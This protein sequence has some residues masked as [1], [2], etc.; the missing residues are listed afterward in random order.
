MGIELYWDD[1][2]LSTLLCVFDGRW[3]WRELTAT[4]K[5]IK[6]ITEDVEHEVAA[7]IDL[8]KGMHLPGGALFNAQ[9]LENV[10]ALLRMGE[11]GTGPILIVGANK[12]VHTVY[13]AIRTMDRSAVA[14]VSFADSLKQARALLNQRRS[15]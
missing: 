11:Q 12:L 8:R 14:K 2:D 7:I 3:D 4:L 6:Q 10:K 1:D 9:N 5:T 15:A 13:D